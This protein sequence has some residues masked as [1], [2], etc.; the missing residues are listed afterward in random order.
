M[1][2][3]AKILEFAMKME[4]EA[5]DFYLDSLEKVVQEETKQLVANL[6]EWEKGH[7]DYL[8]KQKESLEQN[9]SWDRAAE[10]PV[11]EAAGAE[12]ISSKKAGTQAEPPIGELTG[13][14]GVLRMAMSIE[15]DFSNFYKNAAKSVDDSEG[16]EILEMLA[17]WEGGHQKMINEQYDA[18]HKDFM[19]EMGFEPF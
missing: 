17:E 14:M 12:I 11:E 16:R 6:A 4:L 19:A 5:R 1:E 15:T 8:L 2:A 18:L 3:A 13:D 7:Y 9:Q 10:L